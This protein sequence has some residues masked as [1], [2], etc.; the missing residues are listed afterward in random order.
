MK[1]VQIGPLSLKGLPVGAARLL[2][3][4]ELK[5]L[6]AALAVTKSAGGRKKTRKAKRGTSASSARRSGAQEQATR[7]ESSPGKSA[8]HRRIV[9]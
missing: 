4:R 1:R 3:V 9:T 8:A 2:T 7:R 5:A 6:R